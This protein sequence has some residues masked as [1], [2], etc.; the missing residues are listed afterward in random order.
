MSLRKPDFDN[1]WLTTF[2]RIEHRNLVGTP[3]FYTRPVNLILEGFEMQIS[4][5]N[6]TD[7]NTF[8]VAYLAAAGTQ[9]TYTDFESTVWTGHWSNDLKIHRGRR[10]TW[11]GVG[12]PGACVD[13]D[14]Q[15]DVKFEGTH[16]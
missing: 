2:G 5:V 6:R 10:K 1:Q 7:L 3:R 9:V 4:L 8:I 16:A 11:I 14:Y 13:C 12:S 15:I